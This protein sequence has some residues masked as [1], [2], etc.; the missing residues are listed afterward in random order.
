MYLIYALYWFFIAVQFQRAEGSVKEDEQVPW[1]LDP[2]RLFV[3]SILSML[4]GIEAAK[5]YEKE[6]S[7]VLRGK[8]PYYGRLAQSGKYIALLVGVLSL[9]QFVLSILSDR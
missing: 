6:R 8:L 7:A 3:S 5:K 9:V 1:F 2:G 4:K